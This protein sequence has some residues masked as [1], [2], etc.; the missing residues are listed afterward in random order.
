MLN[1]DSEIS[2]EN[3]VSTAVSWVEAT[4]LGS[5]ATAVAIVV[6]ASLGLLFFLGRVPGRRAIEVVFGC[7]ILFGASSI[8][9][10]IMRSLH[11]S[12]SASGAFSSLP[13]PPPAEPA[14][15]TPSP[16]PYDPYAGAAVPPRH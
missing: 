11:G 5:V 10:G 16:Q 8:A 3:A 1:P 15:Q 4:L 12:E 7:F 13:P 9:S 6:V 2:R 14:V